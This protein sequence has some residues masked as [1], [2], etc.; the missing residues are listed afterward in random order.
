M[1]AVWDHCGHL[2]TWV[3]SHS[4]QPQFLCDFTQL[5]Y[6]LCCAFVNC[7]SLPLSGTSTLPSF[8]C[9]QHSRQGWCR[10]W[11]QLKICSKCAGRQHLLHWNVHAEEQDGTA[12]DLQV[13]QNGNLTP[14]SNYCT[15]LHVRYT[16]LKFEISMIL[17]RLTH[18]CTPPQQ[19]ISIILYEKVVQLHINFIYGNSFQGSTNSAKREIPVFWQWT[20]WHRLLYAAKCG[21]NQDSG[22]LIPSWILI[23]ICMRRFVLLWT[24]NCYTNVRSALINS[25]KFR[26]APNIVYWIPTSCCELDIYK[27]LP[28]HSDAVIPALQYHS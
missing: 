8:Q 5:I 17:G 9:P 15:M 12:V 6:I 14:T 13:L 23:S 22:L 24:A 1:P 26:K 28:A 10:H 11:M 2:V 27:K 18:K 25:H 19:D 7:F 20:A 16:V 4:D 3:N 21:K